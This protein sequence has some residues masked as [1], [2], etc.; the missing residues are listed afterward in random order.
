MSTTQ[1]ALQQAIAAARE[2]AVQADRYHEV[3]PVHTAPQAAPVAPCGCGGHG[4]A[5]A[6]PIVIQAPPAARRSYVGPVVMGCAGV[7]AA[8]AL[9]AEVTALL[10]AVGISAIC[11]AVVAVVL[12]G[13]VRD[14]QGGKR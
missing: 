9:L 5:P 12:R 2:A 6:A 10:L 7:V 4:H 11:I 14:L 1:T 3:L 8:G 13:L